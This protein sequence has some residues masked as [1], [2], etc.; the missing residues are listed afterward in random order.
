[1]RMR[2]DGDERSLIFVR[3]ARCLAFAQARITQHGGRPGQSPGSPAPRRASR[4][5]RRMGSDGVASHPSAKSNNAP[6]VRL[7]WTDW[8]FT[9]S[10]ADSSVAA[11]ALP[12]SSRLARGPAP[13]VPCAGVGPV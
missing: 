7:R 5:Q 2:R 11:N 4:R 3:D 13:G 1:M 10:A 8:D 9:A 6:V 12:W